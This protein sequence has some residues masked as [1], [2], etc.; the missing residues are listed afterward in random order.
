MRAPVNVELRPGFFDSDSPAGQPASKPAKRPLKSQARPRVSIPKSQSRTEC[1]LRLA[2]ISRATGFV[3]FNKHLLLAQA[4]V[5][6]RPATSSVHPRIHPG[7]SSSYKLPESYLSGAIESAS[8]PRTSKIGFVRSWHRTRRDP[9][10]TL[11][12]GSRSEI[13][14]TSKYLPTM[15][16]SVRLTRSNQ[17]VTSSLGLDCQLSTGSTT[18]TPLGTPPT[19]RPR[20]AP[21]EDMDM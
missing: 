6:T 16:P 8:A 2:P 20:Q 17:D 11:F 4:A 19:H 18:P 13:Q 7:S 3:A 5:S 9:T 1:P 12:K 21:N 10:E 14:E 15:C